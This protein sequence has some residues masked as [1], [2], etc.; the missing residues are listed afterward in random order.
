MRVGVVGCG[1]WGS[2]HVRALSAM[3][4]VSQVVIIDGRPEVR[5]AVGAD[6]PNASRRWSLTEALDDVDA[7]VIATPP[8][9]HFE[10]T[11][12]AKRRQDLIRHDR[13]TDAWAFKSATDPFRILMPI[14]QTQ[15]DTNPE[16]VQNP[17]Y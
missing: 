7:V 8:E 14:P 12:E 6:F 13:F 4:T 11:A 2:K 17:G 10:L 15:L 3:P 1:Y 5:L 16:L 9:S